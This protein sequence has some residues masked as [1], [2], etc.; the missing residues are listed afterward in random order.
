M[1][2]EWL[3]RCLTRIEELQNLIADWLTLARVEGGTLFKERIKVDLS[4]IISD[5]LKTYQETAAAESVSLRPEC[6][7]AAYTCGATGTA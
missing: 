4:Q 5:I 7:K 3:D 2:H 6:L 1:G